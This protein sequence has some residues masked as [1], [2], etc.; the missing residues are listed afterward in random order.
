MK[1]DTSLDITVNRDGIM[2][3]N[4][5][6]EEFNYRSISESPTTNVVWLLSNLGGQFGFWMGGSVLCIIEFGEIIIDCIW[7]TILKILAW[8]RDRRQKKRRPQY[9]DPPPTVAELVEAYSNSGFQHEDSNQ[10][11]TPIPGTPPPNY[12]SLRLKQ[13]DAIDVISSDDE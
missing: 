3:L 4:I 10:V 6:F 7:I 9:N 12:D 2:R 11:S 8:I 1:R 13:I 5:Y